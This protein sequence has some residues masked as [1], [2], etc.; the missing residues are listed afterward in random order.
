MT[1]CRRKKRPAK[2]SLAKRLIF[3]QMPQPTRRT[4]MPIDLFRRDIASTSAAVLCGIFVALIG[5]ATA[6]AGA[7]EMKEV[8]PV[9][10]QE[11]D[12]NGIYMGF[13]A[14]VVWDHYDIG[15]YRSD[16]NLAQQLSEL[17]GKLPVD[18]FTKGPDLI[19]ILGFASSFAPSHSD[20]DVAPIGGLHIG[21]KKQFGHFVAGLEIGFEGTQTSKGSEFRSFQENFSL[22][23]VLVADTQFDSSRR[24]E[25]NWD[26][27]VGGQLGYAW[28]RFL[29]YATGGYTFAD[30]GVYSS[31]RARTDFFFNGPQAPNPAQGEQFLGRQT[32]RLYTN[33]SDIMN[34][35]YAGG[36]TQ[37]A[38]NQ[39]VTIGLEYRHS[40]FG[41]ETFRFNPASPIFPGAT[42]VNLSS[43]QV[44]F[45]VNIMLG[46]LGH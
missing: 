25:R 26:G 1:A 30:V 9:P 24:A 12:W 16:V 46:H 2:F 19:E 6:L 36:G 40:D 23:D 35:W 27:W 29:F 34:G 7:P 13:N 20:T 45:I 42:N 10:P 15:A 17:E 8:A 3:C 28:G 37:Y 33:T 39:R 32:D 5:A 21:Y 11:I 43:D 31:D 22:R 14:G 18:G 4:T 44:E 38:L 41:D